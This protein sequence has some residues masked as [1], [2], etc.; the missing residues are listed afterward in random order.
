MNRLGDALPS[1]L[2][3]PDDLKH[4]IQGDV[5]LLNDK[6]DKIANAIVPPKKEQN[7]DKGVSTSQIRNIFGTVRMIEHTIH[8]AQSEQ[9]RRSFGLLRPRL[10]YQCGRFPKNRELEKLSHILAASIALVGDDMDAFQ[11]FVDFFEAIL[12]YHRYYG[13]STN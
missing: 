1:D 13:G 4:I 2:I 3:T 8:T 5:T 6:A 10:A 11:N 9:F 7:K 12:A